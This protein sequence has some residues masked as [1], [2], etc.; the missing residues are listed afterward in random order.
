M[1][2][3]KKIAN[4]AHR[5]YTRRFPDN[6][7]EAFRA[8]LELG[9]DGVEF[10]VQ[11]TLDGRFL[12]FHD[13]A[14]GGKAIAE[15]TAEEIQAFGVEGRY[16]IPTL[17]ETLELLGH[18]PLLVVELKRV[19]SLDPFLEILRSHVDVTGVMIVSF[20]SDVIAELAKRAPDIHRAVITNTG[21]TDGEELTRSTRSIAIAMA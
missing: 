11:E 20:D 6:T 13:D 3:M 8:A 15:S 4:I 9:V 7:L 17:Q 14:I 16:R 10:D 12:I 2:R 18:G 19:R 5:G 1:K 21:V